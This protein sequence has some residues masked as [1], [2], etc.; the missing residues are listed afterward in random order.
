MS[1]LKLNGQ[2]GFS[3]VEVLI[4][5]MVISSAFISLSSLND[6]T[7]SLA[8][9]GS[10]NA[11]V[12]DTLNKFATFYD[13]QNVATSPYLNPTGVDVDIFPLAD[14]NPPSSGFYTGGPGVEAVDALRK[15]V[16][17]RAIIK[18]CYVSLSVYPVEQPALGSV[19]GST[20]GDG[21]CNNTTPSL[22]RKVSITIKYG[23]PPERT[24]NTTFLLGSAVDGGNH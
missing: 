16:P 1:G 13:N 19:S 17:A 21:A 24:R 14:Y 4:T 22:L 20:F 23:K 10:V 2:D 12:T 3:M 15:I 5:L 18:I 6:V 8:G 9:K 7:S 11:N